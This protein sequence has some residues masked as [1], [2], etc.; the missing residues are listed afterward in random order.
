MAQ[1]RSGTLQL[2]GSVTTRPVFM[3]RR[4]PRARRVRLQVTEDGEA[5]I[6]MP[7]RAA[8]REASDLFNRHRDWVARQKAKFEE[9]RIKL[10]T[11]PSL[12]AG[13]VLTVNGVAR[14]VRVSNE[15]D[16][17]ALERQLRK[18]A[19]AAI[20]A[21]IALRAPE[22]EVKPTAL[23]VRDQ[24]S[25]WG[26]ASRGG[27]LSFSWRLIL[28]PVDILDY[29][30]VH[31]LAHLRVAGHGRQFWKLVDRYFPDSRGARRWLRE[32]HDELRHAL[33]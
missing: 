33:D 31:E 12:A 28:A 29:V 11:R 32:H 18:E 9:R 14:K 27:G 23:Q 19:R 16:R 13:R 8:A 3:I 17:A 22:M 4:S 21:R 30:V 15:A 25:R 24:K 20:A 1:D 6:V 2:W 5:L 10:A 7:M 26:S